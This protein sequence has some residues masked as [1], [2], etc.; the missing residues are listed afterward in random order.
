METSADA[1]DAVVCVFAA[2]AVTAGKLAQ[3]T[4][5]SDEGQIAI[6]I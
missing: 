5:K 3:Q 6:H 2:F 4:T 1:L